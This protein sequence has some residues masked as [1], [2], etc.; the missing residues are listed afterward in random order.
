MQ[1]QYANEEIILTI[2]IGTLLALFFVLAIVFLVIIFNKKNQ[3]HQKEKEIIRSTYEQTILQS[4]LEIQEQTFNTISQEIHDNVGQTLS[5]AKV[6]LNI[7]EELKTSDRA[8]TMIVDAKENIIQAM[9]DLRDIAKSLSTERIRQIGI[10]GMI[11]QELQRIN[12]TGFI[13]A[14]LTVQGDRQ[15]IN[16]RKKL[17]LHRI[18]QESLQNIIKH[19]QAS[20][21][22]VFFSYLNNTLEI[23]VRDNGKGFD[24]EK[25]RAANNGLGIQNIISR[26]V[27]IGGTASIESVPKKGTTIKL[28]IPYE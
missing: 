16:I 5:L 24:L 12:K 19:A 23:S 15:K 20:V 28:S 1:Y 13:A 27:L 22:D 3:L 2:L 17:I 6:Q 21:I 11:E 4:Q 9:A 14:S 10:G 7:A 8:L 26:T 18:L 25:V